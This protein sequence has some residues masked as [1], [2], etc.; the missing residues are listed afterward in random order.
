[1][2]QTNGK[3][4]VNSWNEWDPLKRVI[5]G[6]SDGSCQPKSDPGWDYYCPKAGFEYGP[7]PEEMIEKATVQMDNFC[8]ILEARGVIVDRAVPIDS[9]QKA[10][11]PDWEIEVMH[12]CMP[13]RD[14]LLPVGNE[15][16]E[17]TMSIRARWYEY[18]CYRPILEEYFKQDQAFQWISAPRP[19]LTDASYEKDYYHN[20]NNVWSKQEKEKRMLE[21]RWHLTEKEPLFDAADG[22][23]LG[24]DI[25]WQASSVSNGLGIDWLGRYFK[26]KGLRLHV[27]QFTGDYHHWHIDV[28]LAPLRPGLCMYSPEWHYITP[29]LEKLFKMNDWELIPAAE[30]VHV[31]DV[32]CG[33][34]GAR[35]STEWISMNTFSIDP[36][37]VCVEAHETKYM[38]QLDKLGF[39]VIPVPFADVFPFGGGLHCATVDVY[40]EGNCEDYFPNQIEGF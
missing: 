13:P 31:Y 30:P 12:G 40:R 10:S 27:A 19:R 14:V 8:R 32:R 34:V 38:E 35:K 29:G 33:V 26:A 3:T 16:L 11:T 28:H 18:L 21:R 39:E 17:C 2:E 24:K 23:R 9:N 4:I 25:I 20:F 15:I 7:M 6:R 22:M 37:T 36:K 5:V 1:M